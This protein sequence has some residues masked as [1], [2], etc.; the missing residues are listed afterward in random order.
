MKKAFTMI[1]LIFVIVIIGILATIA[2]PRFA[3]T[4]DDAKISK[5]VMAIQT[6]RSEIITGIISS[7]KIPQNK[8]ELEDVSNT[9]KELSK[10][11]IIQ[12]V[13]K[14]IEF[15]NTDGDAEICKILTINDSDLSHVTLDLSDGNGT[16]SICKKVQE[17]VANISSDFII[18]GNAIVY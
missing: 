8:E 5:L 11:Y 13:G 3:A 14:T 1:E 12:V 2:I 9:I 15:I 10:D 7:N 17:V 16:S 4:R 18:A 6:F